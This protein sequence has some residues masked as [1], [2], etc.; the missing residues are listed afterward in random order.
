MLIDGLKQ[1][2]ITKDEIIRN[3]DFAFLSRKERDEEISKKIDK[4]TDK[5]KEAIL[6][7]MEGKN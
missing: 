1:S 5:L 6:K 3:V 2:G 4:F 7:S